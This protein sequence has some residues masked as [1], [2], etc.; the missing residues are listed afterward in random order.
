[1]VRPEMIIFT[2]DKIEKIIET[3]DIK[4]KQIDEETIILLDSKTGEHARCEACQ[5][6]L[7]IDNLGHIAHGSKKLYCRN[8]SCFSHYVAERKLW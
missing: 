6:K 5:T 1:M 4:I 2:K 7:N 3:L 8:P